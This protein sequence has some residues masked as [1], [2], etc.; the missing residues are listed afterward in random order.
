MLRG[1]FWLKVSTPQALRPP[2]DPMRKKS[3]MF[4][5]ERNMPDS[6]KALADAFANSAADPDASVMTPRADGGW[7]WRN[8]KANWPRVG[9]PAVMVGDGER[10]EYYKD[11]RLHRDDGPALTYKDGREYWYKYRLLHPDRVP[12]ITP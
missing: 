10:I 11:G 7:K 2:P 6:S 12:P 4:H 1:M 9:A 3:R 8:A 5:L